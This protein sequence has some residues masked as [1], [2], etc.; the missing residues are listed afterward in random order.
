M[1]RAIRSKKSTVANSVATFQS[2]NDLPAPTEDLDERELTYFVRIMKS[3]EVSTWS[4][5]DLTLATDLAMT[6]VQYLDA[7]AAVKRDGRTTVNE[8]G[9]PVTNPET[10]ALN[11]LSSSIRAFT[12]TLGL[13][14]SQRGVSGEHQASRNKAEQAARKV[15][16]K[17]SAD[18]SLL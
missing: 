9:T 4:E 3:R 14:A 13:S 12:A 17:V 15:I 18:D 8:R 5:H 7:M 6:Q 1:P 16:E 2:A 11:Q 10:G